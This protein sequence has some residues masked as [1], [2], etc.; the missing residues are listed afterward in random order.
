[1]TNLDVH[2]S[3]SLL[4]RNDH[5]RSTS[6]MRALGR[7]A[8]VEADIVDTAISNM[9]AG[10]ARGFLVSGAQASGKDTIAPAVLA[11]AGLVGTP[12][13]VAHAIRAEMK[14]IL[15]VISQSSSVELARAEIIANFDVH[16]DSAALYTNLFFE[17]VQADPTSVDVHER[18][19][20]MRRAL[21]WHGGEG[22]THRPGYWVKRAYQ[23][24]IPMLAQGNTVYLTDGRFAGEVDAGRTFGIYT[25]RLFVPESIRC[26]RIEG[27]D[28]F[29]PSV[30]SL[31]HPG[32]IGLDSYWGFDLELDN[33]ANF[34]ANT[35]LISDLFDQHQRTLSAA[36]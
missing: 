13:R 27:R 22:K 30:A 7:W 20:T 16:D 31:R 36:L 19:E 12:A 14:S 33:S 2:T 1:M 15:H 34:E 6:A 17:A 3:S 18:T 24:V 28:G 8:G 26:E 32:E 23:A 4:Q 25:V 10:D 29:S 21:Q 11:Q 9:R 5:P 35:A